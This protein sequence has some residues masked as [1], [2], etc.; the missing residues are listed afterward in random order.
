MLRENLTENEYYEVAMGIQRELPELWRRCWEEACQGSLFGMLQEEIQ[1]R[2]PR[3]DEGVCAQILPQRP[4]KVHGQN[5]ETMDGEEKSSNSRDGGEVCLLRGG[6][7][8]IPVL[9]PHKGR[10]AKRLSKSGRAK[11]GVETSNGRGVTKG[12]IPAFM[13]ELQRGIRF[14]RF[15]STLEFDIADIPSSIQVYFQK[16]PG[17]K[18][19]DLVGIPWRV[20]FALQQDGW[21]LRQDIIWH[22]PNPMPESCRDRCTKAHEYVFLLTKSAKYYYDQQAIA[23]PAVSKPH[24]PGWATSM[25]DRNDRQV[26]NETNTREWAQDGTRNKRSVWTIPTKSFTDAHF[27]TFAPKLVEP[28]LL[29]GTSA[30]GCCPECG[31]PWE[32]VVEK[33]AMVI[34]RS[35]RTHP[36][37]QTRTS[38]TML[39][40]PSSKTLGW[41]PTCKNCQWFKLKEHITVPQPVLDMVEQNGIIPA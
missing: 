13:L 18:P 16:S 33:T 35:S 34:E 39:E 38:G 15:L 5:K 9:G 10:G 29:A 19:K 25:G 2:A 24:G 12:Q 3:T 28:C 32:R 22:K 11:R 20:A 8:D 21:Y 40:P 7:Q 37:G 6:K 23:E 1:K 41:K 27:A 17:L 26:S 31:G 14:V 4:E 30:K 36:K